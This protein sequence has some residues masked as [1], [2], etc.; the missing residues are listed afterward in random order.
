M[1]KREL[2]RSGIQVPLLTF[3]G[4]VFGWTV[5]QAASF[6][7]LDARTEEHTYEHQLRGP[8]SHAVVC[9]KKKIKKS[10]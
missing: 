3:G 6:N 8:I 1:S 9:T 4:N 5:D 7:L 10:K 2:G